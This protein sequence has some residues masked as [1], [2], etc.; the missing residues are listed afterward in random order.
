[1]KYVHGQEC[2][3]YIVDNTESLQEATHIIEGYDTLACDTEIT[4]TLPGGVFTDPYACD[5]RLMQVG[6]PDRDAIVI[7]R[8]KVE[9]RGTPFMDVLATKELVVHHATYDYKQV[10]VSLG[11]SLNM[12]CSK[13]AMQSLALASGYKSGKMRGFTYH[14]LCRDL[15][16][17]WVDKTLQAS[18]W[19]AAFLT[20]AQYEYAALDVGAPRGK[21]YKS[22]L[23]RGYEIL[24]R[25]SDRL[26][27]SEVWDLRQALVPIVGDME[28]HGLLLDH[29]LL[30]ELGEAVGEQVTSSTSTLC[31]MLGLEVLS[32]LRMKSDGTWAR[33]KTPAPKSAKLL[34]YKLGLLKHINKA[35]VPHGIVLPDLTE[36][37]LKPYAKKIPLVAALMQYGM[38]HKLL[39]DVKNYSAANNPVTGYVHFPT[40]II[41]TGTGRMSGSEDKSKK[42]KD[43]ESSKPSAFTMSGKD[44][45][46]KSG[47][48]LSLRSCVKAKPGTVILD[49]DFK[50]QELRIAAALSQDKVMLDTYLLERDNPYLIH[51]E[52]GESYENPMVDLH[53]VATLTMS[54]FSYLKDLPLWEVK[55]ASEIKGPDGTSP[56]SKGKVFNFSVV[57]GASAVSVAEDLGVS[58]K[59]AEAFL[60]AYFDNFSGLKR[61]LDKQSKTANDLRW[62]QLPMGAQI[63]VNEANAKGSADRGA[64]AR[65][66]GNIP[67]Q[68]TGAIMMA[69]ALKYQ[70]ERLGDKVHLLAAIYDGVLL[71]IPIPKGEYAQDDGGNWSPY[72]LSIAHE[73]KQC[74]LDA[75]S[76]ILSP[77]IGQPFPCGADS[78]LSMY[79]SH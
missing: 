49:L 63:F 51:P 55:A 18:N 66:A 59:E 47:R 64:I 76:D 69:L 42:G 57:Y 50:A 31:E 6:F 45:K 32:D 38:Y 14:T 43:K 72:V 24:K 48:Q 5:L 74:L 28:L 41:G 9:V 2:D 65:R 4:V 52:T 17:V 61:W 67:I 79:W 70:R 62:L 22:L 73:A 75:E 30:R 68:G 23:L 25:E 60:K 56:R 26:G 7:D 40:N 58:Q 37:T 54:T 3:F 36:D 21:S 15:L 33:V 10:K 34:N 27:M 71:E 77:Y 19:G 12:L 53:L 35:L 29:D 13:V 46:V 11:V 8:K 1:M 44:I 39:G 20:D 78:K 16:Q